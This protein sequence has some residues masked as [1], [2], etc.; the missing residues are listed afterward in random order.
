ML[1]LRLR[2][3]CLSARQRFVFKKALHFY[4]DSLITQRLK[5]TLSINI[6][7]TPDLIDV[8]GVEGD[9]VPADCS[10]SRRPKEFELRLH[11]YGAE[12][13]SDLL[14]SLAH[15]TVHIKQFARSELSTLD[16]NDQQKFLGKLYPSAE[17]NYWEAPWEIE[18]H[19]RERGLY[20]RFLVSDLSVWDLIPD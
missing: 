1:K 13:F 16:Y 15:E 2:S 4:L 14:S 8:A 6:S 11:Y 9:V 10:C 17:V 18:A 7:V 20:E 5:N 19:G 12:K 3:K